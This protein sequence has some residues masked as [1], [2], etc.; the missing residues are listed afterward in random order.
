MYMVFYLYIFMYVTFAGLRIFNLL[1]HQKN[2]CMSVFGMCLDDQGE[3]VFFFFS[4]LFA[5]YFSF[6]CF[7]RPPKDFFSHVLF[8]S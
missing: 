6:L 1:R 3:C 7:L 8:C 4:F 2:L 5:L